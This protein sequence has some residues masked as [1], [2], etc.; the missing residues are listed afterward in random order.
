MIKIEVRGIG[1]IQAKLSG[2]STAL[3]DKVLPAAINKAADKA[4]AEI[5]RAI[6]EVYNVTATEVRNSIQII[7]ASKARPRAVISIFGSAARKG[8]SLNMIHFLAAVRAA[9]KAQKTRRTKTNKAA[10][11]A[12]GK[13]IGFLIKKGAGLRSIPGSFV[14][15]KGRTIFIRNPDKQSK[16]RPG[17]LNKH[18]Q[19]IDPVQVIGYSQMFASRR[20]SDR[21]LRKVN[22][23]LPIEIDRAIARFLP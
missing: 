14:G 22:I 3:V 4:R 7:G 1:D 16:N 10:L 12:L 8:R 20:I 23:D 13:E 11:R 9:G 15:N 19:A 18:T 17:P 2:L 5:N 6:P 21:V